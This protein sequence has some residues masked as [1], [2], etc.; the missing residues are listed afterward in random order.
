V[1]VFICNYYY[2]CC[3]DCPHHRDLPEVH[4]ENPLNFI[5]QIFVGWPEHFGGAQHDGGDSDEDEV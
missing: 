2:Y 1:R 4:I 5:A 3:C